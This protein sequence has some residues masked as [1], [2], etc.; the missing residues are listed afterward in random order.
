[1]KS[2]LAVKRFDS[3]TS[4]LCASP[5]GLDTELF[6]NI[7]KAIGIYVLRDHVYGEVN[8][9][10]VSLHGCKS[11]KYTIS[12]QRKVKIVRNA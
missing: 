7:A 5:G 11:K 12:L 6:Y 4:V 10:F 2:V 1:M 9:F 8:D 3:W